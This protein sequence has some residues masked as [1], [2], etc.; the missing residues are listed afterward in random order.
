MEYSCHIQIC[1]ENNPIFKNRETII[2]ISVSEMETQYE[3][4]FK[5]RKPSQKT[6]TIFSFKKDLI[7]QRIDL[8]L[9]IKKK[10]NKIS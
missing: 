8:N 6:T 10:I 1:P 4:L 9:W 5:E 3:L 7:S 2:K